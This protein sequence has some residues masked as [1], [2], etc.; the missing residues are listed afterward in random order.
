MRMRTK[1][2]PRPPPPKRHKRSLP[3]VID[4]LV[5][6]DRAADLVIVHFAG[7]LLSRVAFGGR[8]AALAFAEVI[9]QHA[10][11]LPYDGDEDD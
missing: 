6:T 1:R 7:R 3:N 9:K 5:L 8:S 10:E 11:Q 2:P 4:V